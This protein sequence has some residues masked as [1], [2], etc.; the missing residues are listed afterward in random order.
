MENRASHPLSRTFAFVYCCPSLESAV[1]GCRVVAVFISEEGRMSVKEF[2]CTPLGCSDISPILLMEK[3]K[4]TI[5][6]MLDH[7]W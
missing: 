6:F 5:E 1:E 2:H 4:P 3:E 7:C